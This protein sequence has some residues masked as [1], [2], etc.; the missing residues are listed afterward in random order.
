MKWLLE[1]YPPNK[2]WL[3]G[4]SS[5]NST[6]STIIIIIK[7]WFSNIRH[8][9]DHF[10]LGPCPPFNQTPLA[11]PPAALPRRRNTSPQD[12]PASAWTAPGR[13]RRG[14]RGSR[15]KR[16]P[17]GS[18]EPC[19]R[20]PPMDT[21]RFHGGWGNLPSGKRTKNDGKSPLFMG[22]L[23]ISMAIFHSYVSHNQRVMGRTGSEFWYWNLMIF[24]EEMITTL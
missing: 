5:R 10:S 6:N 12:P 23:T 18:G 14:Y 9:H 7:P 19:T 2:P 8:W 22:K 20:T 16:C 21:W 15:W 3:M 24:H 4:K 17:S 13:S 1:E 11:K